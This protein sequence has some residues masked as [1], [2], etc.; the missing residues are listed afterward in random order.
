MTTDTLLLNH[1]TGTARP[2]E[3]IEWA[4]ER[5]SEG[6]DSPSLRILA[7][8]NI[9][10]ERHEVEPYFKKTCKELKIETPPEADDPEG[11]AGFVKKAYDHK[12]I[13]ARE[14]INMMSRFYQN[15]GFYDPPF[16]IW[17][18]IELGVI[19]EDERA[20]ILNYLEGVFEREW[21]LF[22][23]ALQLNLPGDFMDFIRC[24]Q[25]GHIGESQWKYQHRRTTMVDK[26]WAI[27][28]K[29]VPTPK[30]TQTCAACGSY[31]YDGM[32]N[33]E[34]RDA[35]FTQLE[36]KQSHSADA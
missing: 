24:N 13:S 11:A 27:I 15:L 36:H 21:M 1:L 28:F 35:Y 31:R 4:L 30:Y 8:L 12:K 26:I 17:Y 14:A 2:K 19:E 33:P 10:F 16:E 9:R 3:Y 23:R 18:Y 34:V 7:G 20:D 5:L 25:C 32:V 29:S 22:K 6:F